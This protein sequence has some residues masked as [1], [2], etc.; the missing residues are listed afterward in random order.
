MT[1]AVQG[2]PGSLRRYVAE[3]R[4]RLIVGIVGIVALVALVAAIVTLW[5]TPKKHEVAASVL[6]AHV[7]QKHIVVREQTIGT[8]LANS[9]VQLTA[10]IEGRL[11][12]AEFKEGQIVHR[13]DILFR[14]DPRPFQAQ[15]QQAMATLGRDRAQQ[16]S[17]QNDKVRYATLMAQGAASAQQRDQA[18]ATANALAATVK[19]DEATV[20]MAQLNLN[21]AV[22]RSPIDGK[23]GP[24][25]VQPGNLVSAQAASPLV[26]ITQF[27]PVKVSFALPQADLPRVQAQAAR[28]KL[29]ASVQVHGAPET[30]RTASV[31]FTSNAVDDKTGT[32]ELRATFANADGFLVPGQLVDVGVALSDIPNATV[33]PSNAVNVGPTGRYVYVV[34]RAGKAEMRPVTVLNDDGKL[35]AVSGALRK[36]EVVITDGQM[37]VAPGKTVEV[38]KAH[39]KP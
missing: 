31:D 30:S 37:L 13:G 21:Y 14:I 22:I 33:V 9:T 23:T 15:L 5:P 32:I 1:D 2:F 28:Q 4:T 39:R 20:S 11:L 38:S 7:M 19:A 24:I 12:S 17:A 3:P 18:A 6:V 16:V 25:L 10:Q 8:I 26:V 36:G 35:A 27:Q 29:F 34:S